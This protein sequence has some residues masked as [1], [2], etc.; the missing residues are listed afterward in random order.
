MFE[1]HHQIFIAPE[2]KYFEF[3]NVFVFY[4]NYVTHA[5]QP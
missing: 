4:K 3:K 5:F 2:V 1:S